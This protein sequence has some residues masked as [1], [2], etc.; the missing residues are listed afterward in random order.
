MTRWIRA[1]DYCRSAASSLAPRVNALYFFLL[2]TALLVVVLV[3]GL[4]VYF[5][6]KYRKGSNADRSP[7]VPIYRIVVEATY[8]GTPLLI[9]GVMFVWGATLFFDGSAPPH[10]RWQFK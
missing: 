5:A 9:F 3:A 4:I 2:G 6:V 7:I 8:I 1:F 10:T